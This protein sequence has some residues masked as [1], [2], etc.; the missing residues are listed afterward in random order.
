MYSIT[1]TT[2]QYWLHIHIF[3]PLTSYQLHTLVSKPCVL[4]FVI[5]FLTSL[6]NNGLIDTFFLY[7]QAINIM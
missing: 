1:N 4:K 2:H 7:S 5:V 6:I 3:L